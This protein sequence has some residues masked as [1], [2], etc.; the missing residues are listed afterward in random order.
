MRQNDG[1]RGDNGR[2]ILARIV[3]NTAAFVVQG[4]RKRFKIHDGSSGVTYFRKVYEKDPKVKA[5]IARWR[6]LI[7]N[8]APKIEDLER[9]FGV[10]Q[11]PAKVAQA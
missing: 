4:N 7:E 6:F 10:A 5:K 3:L 11:K 8:F 1:Y 9:E 2:M